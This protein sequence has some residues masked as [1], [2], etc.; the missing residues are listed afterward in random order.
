MTIPTQCENCVLLD[1]CKENNCLKEK[2]C[3]SQVEPVPVDPDLYAEMA[4]RMGI[5]GQF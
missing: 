5:H 3:L 4:E 2:P 1:I